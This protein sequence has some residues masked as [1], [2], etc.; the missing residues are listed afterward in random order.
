MAQLQWPQPVIVH[1]DALNP[2]RRFDALHDGLLAQ[3]FQYF[4]LLPNP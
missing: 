1:R 4:G 2:V 3:G